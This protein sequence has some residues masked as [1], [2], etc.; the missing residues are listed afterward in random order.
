MALQTAVSL[1]LSALRAVPMSGSRAEEAHSKSF[2]ANWPDGAGAGA[3]DQVWSDD[4][5]LAVGTET[6]DLQSLTQLD[7]NG[8]TLRSAISFDGV[9]ALHVKNNSATGTLTLGGAG[10]NDWDGAGTPFQVATG[11]IDIQPGGVFLWLAPTAGGGAVA[12]GA[13]DLLVEATVAT[14]EYEIVV[15]GLAT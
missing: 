9:K 14:V 10:A 4:R 6:H 7:D 5:S 3:A 2:S 12:A 8:A 13:K 15:V 1:T 11:K